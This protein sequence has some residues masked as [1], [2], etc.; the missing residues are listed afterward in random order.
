MT[1]T[2]RIHTNEDGSPNGLATLGATNPSGGASLDAGSS[3]NVEFTES[4]V[5]V[6]SSVGNMLEQ[7]KQAEANEDPS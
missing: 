6:A 2:L 4:L 7:I 3:T 1:I 5:H